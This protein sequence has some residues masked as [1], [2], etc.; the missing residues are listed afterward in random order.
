M[1][2]ASQVTCLRVHEVSKQESERSVFRD[3]YLVALLQSKYD[4]TV[5]SRSLETKFENIS[6]YLAVNFCNLIEHRA[7]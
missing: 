6:L 5:E 1:G 4:V 7:F 3:R 2:L